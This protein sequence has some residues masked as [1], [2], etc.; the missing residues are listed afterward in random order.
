MRKHLMLAGHQVSLQLRSLDALNPAKTLARGFATVSKGET[1][2]TS[3][4]Q[5]SPGDDIRISLADGETDAR[6]S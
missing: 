4:A 1:L 6:I 2:V 5:L 3:V